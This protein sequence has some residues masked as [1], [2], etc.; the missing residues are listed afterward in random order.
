MKSYLSLVSK[1][2]SAHKK[3]TRL[4]IA[5]VALSVALI[6]GIFSMLDV[7]LKFEKIQVIHDVGNYHLVLK[8]ASD[9]ERKAIS[10]RIDVKHSGRWIDVGDGKVNGIKSWFGAI[11]K[12]FAANMNLKVSEGKFPTKPDEIM[13]ERWATENTYLDVKIND[14][15]KLSFPNNIERE[16]VVSGIYNDLSNT[17]ASGKPGVLLSIDEANARVTKPLDILFLVEFKE[18][19]NI[20]QAEK[21]IKSTLNISDER[22]G[23]NNRLLAVMGQGTSN[24]IIGLYATG[25]VLFCIV[26]VAGV[27]MIYNM[28]NIS[29][30][31]R[32][33]QFGLLRCIGASQSQTKK[34]V[35]REGLIIALKAIPIGVLAGMLITY[36]CSGI[37]KFYNHQ[38]FKEIP[39]F[40]LSM[41][42]IGAGIIIGF[43]TVYIASLLPAKKAAQISPVN[44]MTGNNEMKNT[45]NK[46]RSLLTKIFRAEIAMGINNAVV[47]K[48]TLILMASSIA[49]S[50]IMFLGFQVFIDFMHTGLKTTKPYTPDISLTSKQGME[51]DLYTKLSNIEGV[52]K[53]YGRMFGY[54]NATF[55]ATR[56]ISNYKESMQHI[57]VKDNGLFVPLE[58]SW[59]ISYDKNQFNWAKQDLIA[60]ELSEDKMNAQNGV[61]VV[62]N[63]VRNHQST[64]TTNLQLGD[65]IYIETAV[66]T[67]QLTVIGL[68]RSVPFSDSKL[69][70][71]TFITTEKL[72]TE[73]TGES[74]FKIID[75]QLADKNQEQ[76]VNEIKRMLNS[77]I[78]F[79]DARQKNAE[80]DQTFFTMAVFIYGFVA[81]IALI[82]ILNIINTMNTS[83]ISK[84]RYFGVMRA[85][86][87]SSAQLHKMVL[88]E[89]ATYTLIGCLTGCILGITLQKVLITYL[90]SPY[91]IIWKFPFVQ[92]LLI[93]TITLFVTVV[94]VINPLKK[95]GKKG[96]SEV[97]NSL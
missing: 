92:I 56:L 70:L 50:I 58:S 69:N 41:T 54:V 36:I 55:D 12:D 7:F 53:V 1:Y 51:D 59:L 16:Y 67:K 46:K 15:V 43:L 6:T 31:D 76:T 88:T 38:L 91:D 75:I 97:V 34:L 90:L 10:S 5:S 80:M 81:V 66:G 89:A 73:W 48:K 4:T 40:S 77:S 63:H 78:S 27:I 18:K 22:I 94:S 71:A 24:S 49:M 95:I 47:K 2:F 52:K 93:L 29:V 21:D 25:A 57:K 37:L 87:M 8:D 14:T 26:L 68:L 30:M 65:K 45:K 17:K 82:S 60:G 83:V 28:F 9:K 44:A 42:G 74:K 11:D 32:V 85:I 3:K 13:I 20:I 23:L 39:L 72:F 84:T 33:R 19:V 62:V 86:G 96:I 61:I 64:K 35:R 79:L